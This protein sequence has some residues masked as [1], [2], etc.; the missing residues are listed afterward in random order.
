MPITVATKMG[1]RAERA[2]N[3][4][5]FARQFGGHD[6]RL[7]RQQPLFHFEAVGSRVAAQLTAGC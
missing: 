1:R 2:I 3:T 6:L 4:T 7:H 5:R